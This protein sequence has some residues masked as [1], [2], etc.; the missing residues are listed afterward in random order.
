M[1]LGTRA[2]ALHSG[3]G[4]AMVA[5]NEAHNLIATKRVQRVLIVATNDSSRHFYRDAYLR[6]GSWL[7]HFIFGDG[8]GAIALGPA[9][10]GDSDLIIAT[11]SFTSHE[12]L[13]L[14]NNIGNNG[15]SIYLYYIK[16]REV[17]IA[18]QQYMTEVVRRLCSQ[19]TLSLETIDH[20]IPHQVNLLVL[21]RFLDTLGM[22]KS[23]VEINVD[24]IGNTASACT[25]LLFD[26]ARKA[27]KLKPGEKTMVVAMGAGLHAGGCVVQH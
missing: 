4:G 10:E 19:F 20:F 16:G 25:L 1:R 26:R 12:E 23:K 9:K 5:I 27:G 18:Y 14:V 3:C 22:D 24:V 15:N 11:D 6:Y 17:E 13:M 21:N 7:S 2:H 8:S